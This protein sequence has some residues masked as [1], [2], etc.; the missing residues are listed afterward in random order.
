MS[1][2]SVTI[3]SSLHPLVR[4]AV[5]TQV[6]LQRPDVVVLRHEL[7]TLPVDGCVHRIERCATG[8]SDRS[9]PV[10]DGCCLSCLLRD[11]TL[12]AL[13]ALGAV[14]VL[15]VLPACVEP[16]MLAQV[17]NQEQV[18]HVDA[19]VAAVDPT[20]LASDL[21]SHRPLDAMDPATPAG[22]DRC[23]A[24]LL[25]RQLQYADVVLHPRADGREGA[26]LD[27]LAPAAARHESDIEVAVWLGTSCHDPERLERAMATAVPRPHRQL[28]R[29]GVSSATWSRRRPLHPQRFLDACEDGTFRDVV[30]ANGHVWVAT[31]PGTVLEVEMSGGT[32]ELAA[33]DAWLV[34]APLWERAGVARRRVADERWHPY[35]GDRAQDLQ[36]VCVE[37]DT[38]DVVAALDACLLT[39]HE[40]AEGEDGWTSWHDPFAPWFGDEAELLIAP[41]DAS[42]DEETP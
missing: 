40:L 29:H 35:W 31:R 30:R 38:D 37:Q 18:G 9:L 27:A 22:D 32:Y 12:A 25:G 41:T 21:W 26:L 39:D 5:V 20:E 14:P 33:V 7:G 1:T 24:A 3:L 4:E 11:D 2:P 15:L 13:A 36:F 23:V 10:D 28:T 34:A 19:V 16:A 8:E 42:I 6:C 17:L